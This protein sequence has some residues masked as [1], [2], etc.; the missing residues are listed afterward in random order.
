MAPQ[1][2]SLAHR[3]H[4]GLQHLRQV[5]AAAPLDLDLL[6]RLQS[7]LVLVAGV[8]QG[9]PGAQVRREH[10]L[11]PGVHHVRRRVQVDALHVVDPVVVLHQA[12]D[13]GEDV[14]CGPAGQRRHDRPYQLLAF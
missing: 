4:R 2:G 14:R 12:L 11:G 10:R 6:D 1:P 8:A 7:G 13:L 3:V 5:A 9:R